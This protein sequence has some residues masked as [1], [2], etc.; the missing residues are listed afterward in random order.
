M[1][2]FLIFGMTSNLGIISLS[3]SVLTIFI[4]FMLAQFDM[5]QLRASEDRTYTYYRCGTSKY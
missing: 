4:V 1:S 5:A 2:F 3:K